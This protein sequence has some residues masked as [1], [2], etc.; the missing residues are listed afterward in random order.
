[1]AHRPTPIRAA[2]CLMVGAVLWPAGPVEAQI[3]GRPG[4][5]GRPSVSAQVVAQSISRGTEEW[6]FAIA[7]EVPAGHHGYIDKGDDGFFIPFSF[8]F[9]GLEKT[10]VVVEMTSVP[11]G[12]R[13][14]K[15]RA[16]VL[17]G[18]A[19]FAFRLVP[20]PQPAA[21]A[22]ANLRYQICSDRTGICF[23]PKVLPILVDPGS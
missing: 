18:R 2:I 3:G 10:G 7:V 8:S 12:V 16:Q 14:D 23:P 21:G 6:S 19:D 5:Q 22:T 4:R 9:P 13:D 11:P 1:M 17:R 15:V 20:A